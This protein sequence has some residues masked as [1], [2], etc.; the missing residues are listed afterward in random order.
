MKKRK[1]SWFI[2]LNDVV[3]GEMLLLPLGLWWRLGEGLGHGRENGKS[4]REGV[5]GGR[6]KGQGIVG[7]NDER[8][9]K[10]AKK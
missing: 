2:L 1:Q 10:T 4:K 5:T 6:G 8:N 9:D 3:W 7:Y